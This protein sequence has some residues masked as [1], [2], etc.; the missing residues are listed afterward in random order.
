ML[1]GCKAGHAISTAVQEKNLGLE[2]TGISHYVNWWK[3]DY[4]NVGNYVDMMKNYPLM[5][6]FGLKFILI[7]QDLGKK[8]KKHGEVEQT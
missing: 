6:K 4:I 7:L 2:T 1:S 8:S 5:L 3:E